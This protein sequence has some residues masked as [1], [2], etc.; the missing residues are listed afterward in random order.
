VTIDVAVLGKG[1]AGLAAAVACAERGLRVA[2]VGPPG[3]VRWRPEYG[4][5]A[6]VLERAGAGPFLEHRWP[7]TAVGFGPDHRFRIERAYA[8]VDKDALRDHLLQRIER[9]GGAMAD[10]IACELRHNPAGTTVALAGGTT[11]RAGLVIDATGHDSPFVATEG[12][13]PPAFQTAVGYTLADAADRADVADLMDWTPADPDTPEWPPSFLY[14]L[15]FP[16][17]RLFVE[18]TVLAGRPAVPLAVLEDRLRRRLRRLGLDRHAVVSRELCRIPMGGAL[19]AA[20]QRVVHFGGAA[21]MVHPAT[22]YQLAAALGAAPALADALADTLGR[23]GADPVAAAHAATAAVWPA[24]RR[25]A[26]ALFT[27]GL[28]VLLP[29]GR[30]DI[31]AFFSTFFAAPVERWARYLSPDAGPREVAAL[32]ADLFPRLPPPL[33]RHLVRVALRR[34]RSG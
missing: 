15:P 19:P 30:S 4:D 14:R 20:G 8:R 16:D 6:E 32:M 34:P 3:P 1:P 33:R 17:G 7:W 13:A 31:A 21:R 27:F 24:P 5:W 9:A 28:E 10:G 12:G 23:R 2:V 29:L 11:L 26:R 25:R 22:G 18:E